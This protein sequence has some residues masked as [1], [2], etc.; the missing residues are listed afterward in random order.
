[1]MASPEPDVSRCAI[2][3]LTLPRWAEELG[4]V[5]RLC[6][7]QRWVGQYTSITMGTGIAAIVHLF[8]KI[9]DGGKRLELVGWRCHGV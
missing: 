7:R 3:T 4:A 9:E 1:M 8:I 2:S 6:L 5:K